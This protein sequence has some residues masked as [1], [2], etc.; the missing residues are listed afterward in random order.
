[1]TELEVDFN[2][3]SGF[4]AFQAP[5]NIPT[6]FNGDK[7]VIYGILKSKAASDDPL[8]SGVQGTVSLKGQISGKPINHT[9]SFD[10]PA[11]PIK[12][13]DQLESS[14]GFDML[15]I[16]QLAAKS[17]LGDWAAGK[18]WS[19]TSLTHEREQESTNL[20]IESGVISEHT[21]FVA[22]DVEQNQ[23]IEGAITL[24]DVTATMAKQVSSKGCM[25]G[26][27]TYG[28]GGGGG[29]GGRGGGG[30]GGGRVIN[31]CAKSKK[32]KACSGAIGKRHLKSAI[33][34]V[35]ASPCNPYASDQTISF[36]DTFGSCSPP[37]GGALLSR[38]GAFSELESNGKKAF[39][40]RSVPT[41]TGGETEC[42][43]TALISLQ[44]A[45]GYWLLGDLCDKFF[46]KKTEAKTK[47]PPNLS[48]DI[49][50]TIVGLI[51]LE[52]RYAKQKDEWELVALKAEMWLSSQNL[53]Q[54]LSIASLKEMAKTAI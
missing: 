29:G 3:P 47:R 41:M 46:L 21:A 30:R 44:Q 24:Y 2:L 34:P 16:H 39:I 14:T 50:A 33:L 51:C 15:I 45:T 9:V 52:S 49:W 42:N 5:S 18:G 53:P 32:K 10:V 43:L 8:Q 26:S 4:E 48:E 25:S 36:N 28:S 17:L 27:L 22:V 12:G 35:G 31:F 20:S 38:E 37:P 13:E 23:P 40:A 6:I 11:P 1:M 7:V 19:S 54:G